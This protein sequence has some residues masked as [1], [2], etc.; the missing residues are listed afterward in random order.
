MRAC[1]CEP[2]TLGACTAWGGT[3]CHR[4]TRWRTRCRRQYISQT[5]QGESTSAEDEF[6]SP[7]S[8]VSVCLAAAAGCRVMLQTRKTSPSPPFGRRSRPHIFNARSKFQGV[9]SPPMS[10]FV[11]SQIY[12]SDR[13][14][15]KGT[16]TS[17]SNNFTKKT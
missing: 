15:K 2:L 4:L 11:Y 12:C 8:L 5:Y 14:A 16:I 17:F 6:A 13:V 9:D 10:G 7:P 1:V 3:A